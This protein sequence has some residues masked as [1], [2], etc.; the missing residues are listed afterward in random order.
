MHLTWE[1]EK[2]LSSK[3]YWLCNSFFQLFLFWWFVTP[4]HDHTVSI[5]WNS[6]H[7]LDVSMFL[8]LQIWIFAYQELLYG[9]WIAEE[10][11]MAH[12]FNMPSE[13]PI[14]HFLTYYNLSEILFVS[15]HRAFVLTCFRLFYCSSNIIVIIIS[16][17]RMT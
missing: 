3:C 17:L 5:R 11:K 6:G 14:V 7:G 4:F 10:S 1:L 13:M 2:Y 16:R 12:K 9:G 8:G 15:I